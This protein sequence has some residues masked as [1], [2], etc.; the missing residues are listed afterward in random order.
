ML[1]RFIMWIHPII[2]MKNTLKI[3]LTTLAVLAGFSSI[4]QA[5][6]NWNDAG[7]DNEL[8]NGD[9]WDSGT[10]PGVS[11]TGN[12]I[13]GTATHS[14]GT[15]TFDGL[16]VGFQGGS[17]TLTQTGGS[18]VTTSASG[19]NGFN[20]ALYNGAT[21]LYTL[22]GGDLSFV[23][24]ANNIGNGSGSNGTVH[25]NGGVINPGDNSTLQIGDG[26]GTGT[27]RVSAGAINNSGGIRLNAFK[28]AGTTLNL[29]VVGSLATNIN[30]R[31]IWVGNGSITNF[32]L[33][34]DTGGLTVI[35]FHNFSNRN[36]DHTEN[37]TIDISG[38][39]TSN[40]TTIDLIDAQYQ[41]LT[42]SDFE[43]MTILGG[44]GD[45]AFTADGF[46]T[47]LSITNIAVT[48]NDI[49][50][51]GDGLYD[52][53]ETN[54]GTYVS[55]TDTGTDPNVA[56]SDGDGLNDSV[57][58]QLMAGLNPN[59][60]NTTLIDLLPSS[61]GGLTEQDIIDLRVG[62]QL[63]AIVDNQATLQIVIEESADLSTWSETQTTDVQ[64]TVPEGATKQFFRYSMAD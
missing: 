15:A 38:Y 54:T 16:Q 60:D 30:F 48:S 26:G 21:G 11:G 63:A 46:G 41:A 22:S 19:W 64:V 34:A 3:Q 4:A 29:E 52:Y 18:L 51:D 6:I 27:I 8:L 32:N 45:F 14:S 35:D 7:S 17:G 24:G 10:F 53:V 23:G 33:T 13:N 62:S 43:N 20:V 25:V 9:N 59:Q 44:T 49:D 42:A 39:D 1:Y 47:I 31:D 61:G 36:T 57:E 58:V 5:D 2:I 40:G 50:T 55:A 28:S 56:D 37:L 12:H